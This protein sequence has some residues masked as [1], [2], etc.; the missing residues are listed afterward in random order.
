MKIRQSTSKRLLR[1][2][3]GSTLEEVTISMGIALG[4]I[5]GIIQGYKV[6]MYRVEWA[7]HNSAAQ[8]LAAQRLEQTR[9]AR[10]EP[11]GLQAMDELQAANFPSVVQQLSVPVVGTNVPS[12]RLVTTISTV[13]VDPP[14]RFVQVDC[15]WTCGVKGPFTNSAVA[16]RS[17]DV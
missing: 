8:A 15:I 12:A 3:M 17:P 7:L 16:L 2:I 4:S 11:N 6:S 13:S 10:W 14:V 5:L 9:S 1:A